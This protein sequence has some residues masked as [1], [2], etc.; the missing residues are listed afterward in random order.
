MT[1]SDGF[2]RVEFSLTPNGPR[3][4]LRLGGV[5]AKLAGKCENGQICPMGGTGLEP[6]TFSV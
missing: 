5:S 4:P 2:R 3:N 1:K 6:V